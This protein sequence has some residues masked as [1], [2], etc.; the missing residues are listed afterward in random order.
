ML[1][2][3]AV[4]MIKEIYKKG[5][6]TRKTCD[7]AFGGMY[8]FLTYYLRKKGLIE[9]DSVDGNTKYWR[10]TKKGKRVAELIM[11]IEKAVKE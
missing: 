3:R 11:E 8:Y 6:I 9:V 1:I 2:P 4:E 7:T 5:K 10:L